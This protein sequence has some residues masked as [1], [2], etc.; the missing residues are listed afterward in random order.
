MSEERK[1]EELLH[2]LRS[3]LDSLAPIQS[4]INALRLDDVRHEA[5]L[6]ALDARLTAVHESLQIAISNLESRFEREQANVDIK[7]SERVETAK[8]SSSSIEE[9]KLKVTA[10][11]GKIQSGTEEKKSR[12]MMWTALITG[13]LSIVSVIVA[14]LIKY[15]T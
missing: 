14:G 8:D 11:E 10:L 9:L 12:V 15:L 4:E 6:N 1:I 5:K 7:I 13:I 2:E 3:I